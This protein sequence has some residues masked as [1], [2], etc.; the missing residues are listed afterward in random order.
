MSIGLRKYDDDNDVCFQPRIIGGSRAKRRANTDKDCSIDSCG[1]NDAYEDDFISCSR[2][3]GTSVN[4]RKKVEA[5]IYT[6]IRK[7]A[8]HAEVIRTVLDPLPY[9]IQDYILHL[10]NMN[11]DKILTIPLKVICN[12]QR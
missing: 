7:C 2:R 8:L 6:R 3:A 10:A 9:D 11:S 4:W 1:W 12:P 5:D